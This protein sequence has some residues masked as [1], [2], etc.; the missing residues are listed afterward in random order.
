MYERGAVHRQ[1]IRPANGGLSAIG[2][3]PLK[4]RLAFTVNDAQ[5]DRFGWQCQIAAA[6][7]AADTP[8]A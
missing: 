1:H 8:D 2:L 4:N 5:G 3:M 6:T 7:I